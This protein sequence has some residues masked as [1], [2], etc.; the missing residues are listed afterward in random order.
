MMV[1]T[2]I[3]T[4]PRL[5]LFFGNCINSEVNFC[6]RY[7]E[8]QYEVRSRAPVFG[9]VEVE[10]PHTGRGRGFSLAMWQDAGHCSLSRLGI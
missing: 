10:Y 2:G 7:L 3:P 5:P 9:L 4:L 1:K 8:G 6:F